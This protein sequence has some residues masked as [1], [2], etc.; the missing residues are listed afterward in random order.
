MKLKAILG[1]PI[2]VVALAVASLGLVQFGLEKVV[3]GTETATLVSKAS[4][5]GGVFYQYPVNLGVKTKGREVNPEW[6]IA[7]YD[8]LDQLNRSE[9]V[10]LV[11][12]FPT[13]SGV[14]VVLKDDKETPTTIEG[15]GKDGRIF[16]AGTPPEAIAKAIAE[17]E[18]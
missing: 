1:A 12:I 8:E 7:I 14:R 5:N 18:G 11:Q 10:G 13:S 15:W 4:Y 9:F 2:V 17:F 16:T 3:A 6:V